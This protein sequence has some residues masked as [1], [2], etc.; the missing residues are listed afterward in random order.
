MIPDVDG[1]MRCMVQKYAQL[2]AQNV[3]H[4]VAPFIG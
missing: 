1:V 2:V 4:F 3:T